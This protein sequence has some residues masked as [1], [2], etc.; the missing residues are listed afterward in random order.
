MNVALGIQAKEH[1]IQ[2]VCEG[3]FDDLTNAPKLGNSCPGS[4]DLANTDDTANDGNS[5]SASAS[6][7]A[8]SAANT[9]VPQPTTRPSN[10][11]APLTVNSTSPGG[12]AMQTG[13]SSA[14]STKMPAAAKTTSASGTSASPLAQPS[15][16]AIGRQGSLFGSLGGLGIAVLPILAAF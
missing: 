1:S 6:A 9:S 14:G 13:A 5:A 10:S 16:G 3:H 11:N 12:Q 8:S 4:E 2:S 15:N 7:S